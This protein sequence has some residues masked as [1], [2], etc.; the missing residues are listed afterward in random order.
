MPV[1]QVGIV[2]VLVPQGLVPV[3]V[4]VRLCHRPLMA[5]GVVLVMGMAVLV[6]QR[7]VGVLVL[8]PFRQVQP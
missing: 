7:L 6:L 8:V 2:G 4:R 5:M 1:M 3:R